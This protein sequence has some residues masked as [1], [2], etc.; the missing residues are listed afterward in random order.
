[1]TPR[2]RPSLALLLALACLPVAGACKKNGASATPAEGRGEREAEV[3]RENYPDRDTPYDEY[4]A[5]A[6][7]RVRF[8]IRNPEMLNR[9]L[10]RLSD[11]FSTDGPLRLESAT[12]EMLHEWGIPMPVIEQLDPTG[13]FGLSL[14]YP[15]RTYTGEN[16]IMVPAKDLALLTREVVTWLT[17]DELGPQRWRSAPSDTEDEEDPDHRDEGVYLAQAEGALAFTLREAML[18]DAAVP[19]SGD[20]KAHDLMLEVDG[21]ATAV[22]DLLDDFD[23][24]LHNVERGAWQR[25][26]EALDR[27]WVSVDAQEDRDLEF[28]AGVTGR[29][30]GWDGGLL[31]PARRAPAR[32][33]AVMPGGALAALTASW[34]DPSPALELINDFR[35]SL[36]ASVL[37]RD[38]LEMASLLV[39]HI[40]EDVGIAIY[41]D[42]EGRHTL[43]LAAG[44]DSEKTVAALATDMVELF[45]RSLRAADA[46]ITAKEV[47][48]ELSQEEAAKQR[49][50]HGKETLR[51][52]SQRVESVWMEMREPESSTKVMLDGKDRFR[53][54][55]FVRDE[56]FFVVMGPGMDGVLAN[57]GSKKGSRLAQ[58]PGLLAAHERLD[59]CQVCGM[60][61]GGQAARSL[62]GRALGDLTP[63]RRAEARALLPK[64]SK[65][66]QGYWLLRTTPQRIEM[67][68][69]TDRARA[70]SDPN[71]LQAWEQFMKVLG[72]RGESVKDPREWLFGLAPSSELEVGSVG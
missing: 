20:G 19:A 67:R 50:S 44:V 52:G 63:E 71:L 69:L 41:V 60:T 66:D 18:D 21:I 72:H 29:L 25:R 28:G 39:D 42:E 49:H 46:E 13:A 53:M 32:I 10:T 6:N 33:A 36:G 58:A 23:Q 38:F 62:Y 3:V 30:D 12:R 68:V 48:G 7:M 40:V 27:M 35:P 16:W 8:A 9:E 70:I 56:T 54:T 47:A 22:P 26:L 64:L 2:R 15:L 55:S 5:Q 61:D 24:T 1:M 65:G 37:M 59:G 34:G 43:V 4:E 57:M 45:D 51:L 14:A 11:V 31:G 17:L